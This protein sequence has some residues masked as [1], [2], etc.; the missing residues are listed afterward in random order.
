MGQV[1]RRAERILFLGGDVGMAVAE[2]VE[3]STD[4][5]ENPSEA[6]RMEPQSDG[7]YNST[8]IEC[9][10]N[11]DSVSKQIFES[12]VGEE[13]RHYRFHL[14]TDIQRFGPSYLALQSSAH[15][16]EATRPPSR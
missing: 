16:P 4:A 3:K 2:P 9:A 10:A 5:M 7:D 1:E 11:E 6:A 13:E 12:L 14:Q 8:A 15:M